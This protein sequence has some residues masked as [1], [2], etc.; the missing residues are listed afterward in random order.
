MHVVEAVEPERER[1]AE[2][3]DDDLEP[4]EPVE[5][6][7]GDHPEQ[8]GAGL[9]REPPDRPVEAGVEQRLDHRS[10]RG[11][12]VQVDG[13]VQR[14]RGLEDVPELRVVQVL[15][16]RVRVDDHPVEAQ[17]RACRARSPRRPVRGLRR[18]RGQAGEAAGVVRAGLGEPVVGQR[19]LRDGE[20]FAEHLDA[21][22]GQR[23]DLAVHAGGVHVR[24]PLF[25][26]V[27]EGLEDEP[28]T[29]ARWPCRRSPTGCGSRGRRSPLSIMSS[30]ILMISG[31]ANASSVAIRRYP[32]PP[33]VRGGGASVGGNVGSVTR[34][35]LPWRCCAR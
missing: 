8:V 25:A 22:R 20:V 28:G 18:D 35:V 2:V 9:H 7:A 15:A 12:G 13:Y 34:P 19:G 23:D 32:A 24:E 33:P 27:L 3:A 14:L 10:G 26:E 17:R 30:Q 1:L 31:V 5:D 6:A 16:P 21:G 29:L 11:V 4:R